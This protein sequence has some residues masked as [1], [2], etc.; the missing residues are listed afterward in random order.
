MVKRY[1]H[2]SEGG[3]ETMS[4]EGETW[5]VNTETLMNSLKR[6]TGHD[7]SNTFLW[8]EQCLIQMKYFNQASI[9]CCVYTES[10]CMML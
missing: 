2:H 4:D 5:T 8:Y 9:T 1:N 3:F 10:P 6:V 7:L